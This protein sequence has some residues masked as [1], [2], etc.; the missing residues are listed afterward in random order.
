MNAKRLVSCICAL[1]VS[2]ASFMTGFVSAA[3]TADVT[4]KGAQ[5]EVAAGAKFELA[6]D[7]AELAGDAKAGF[8]GCEFAITYDPAK[9]KNVQVVEGAALSQTG[10]TGAELNKAPTIGSQVSMVN[11][12]DYNC[13]DYNIVNKEGADTTVAVL[14]CTGLESADYWVKDS[15]TLFTFKGTLTENAKVGDVI[16]VKIVPITR[17]ENNSMVFGRIDGDKDIKLSSAVAQQGQITVKGS[18]TTTDI[19]WGDLNCDG[20]VNAVDFVYMVHAVLNKDGALASGL[21][22]QGVRNGNMFG[23]LNDDIT[24]A[25]VLDADDLTCLVRYRIESEESPWR[26]DKNY[27]AESF[28]VFATK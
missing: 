10:A 3:D 9:I 21:S 23:T 6:I 14:W 19:V 22:E 15:G 25:D 26:N 17:D 11:K 16:P 5:I 2:S 13:F 18:E 28:S 20:S 1:A 27:P 8:S 24:D 12:G 4:L 7:L